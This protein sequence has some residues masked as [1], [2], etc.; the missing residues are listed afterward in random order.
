MFFIAE[1]RFRFV[2]LGRGSRDALDRGRLR[3]LE[4]GLGKN[5]LGANGS[6]SKQYPEMTGSQTR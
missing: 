2:C 4:I 1:P 6:V 5:R 3:T